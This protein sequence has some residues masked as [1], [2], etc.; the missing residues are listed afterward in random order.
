MTPPTL[1][2]LDI[3]GTIS[4]LDGVRT[5]LFGHARRRYRAWLRRS[6]GCPEA[7]RA[8]DRLRAEIA[9]PAA[10]VELLAGV[11]E[12]WTDRDVKSPALKE[13]QGLIWRE[14]FAAGELRS[15]V[16]E[17][18]R[19]ALVRCREG[20]VPVAIYSSGS[21]LAQQ[22]WLGHTDFGDLRPFVTYWFDLVN[23]GGK[24]DPMSYR[25][26][27]R[28]ASVDSAAIHFFTDAP[29]ELDAASAAGWTVIGVNR[30]GNPQPP[31]GSPH[32]WITTF[33]HALTPG[34]GPHLR[35]HNDRPFAYS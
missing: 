31:D 30:P 35:R 14:G 5:T 16:F 3:E 10:D 19:G 32:P 11:L 27:S 12:E 29:T 23:A 8:L 15:S 17:D 28:H 18:V 13:I 20:E 33:E 1:V 34:P 21:V 25:R 24:R 2:V 4:S 9:R 7:A 26:I 6:A 22:L